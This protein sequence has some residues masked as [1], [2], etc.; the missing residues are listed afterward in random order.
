MVDC[1]IS[2]MYRDDSREYMKIFD[3]TDFPFFSRKSG[4]EN[5]T[6]IRDEPRRNSTKLTSDSGQPRV[7]RFVFLRT[8][9]VHVE[10]TV[11]GIRRIWR[12]FLETTH[13]NRHARHHFYLDPYVRDPRQTAA[14]CRFTVTRV[15]RKR[16]CATLRLSHCDRYSSLPF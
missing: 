11:R 2:S 6:A 1:T 3:T 9:P 5:G 13:H 14:L 10:V 15:A 16:R 7:L 12:A 4:R 8:A